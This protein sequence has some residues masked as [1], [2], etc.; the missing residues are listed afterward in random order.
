MCE[1]WFKSFHISGWGK[2]KLSL[3]KELGGGGGS[4]TYRAWLSTGIMTRISNYVHVKLQDVI[5]YPYRNFNGG[6]VRPPL[7]LGCR[8]A[9]PQNILAVTLHTKTLI[10]DA[11]VQI[12]HY[13]DVTMSLMASQI[14]SLTS[15]YST[16]Y[17]GA[18]QRKHQSSAPLAFVWG[19]HRGPVN[20]THKW[21][22]TRK[23]FPFDDVI[24]WTR[25]WDI[26]RSCESS[27]IRAHTLKHIT[28]KSNPFPISRFIRN[29]WHVILSF[30]SQCSC[31]IQR[32]SWAGYQSASEVLDV[33]YLPTLIMDMCIASVTHSRNQI[34]VRCESAIHCINAY[35]VVIG[36][37]AG[38]QRRLT[39]CGVV[40][41]DTAVTMACNN[42]QRIINNDYILGIS[43]H[44]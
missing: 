7:K 2:A 6:S 12:D 42:L 37:T 43:I 25:S 27:L 8:E 17:L 39:T 23:K 32:M 22:V 30:R 1:C 13:D 11:S 40:N 16:V 21:S 36:G 26:S 3:M 28:S 38:C 14:T 33:I 44:M 20:S 15:V 10:S 29:E 31:I 24:M 18:D 9:V 4:F 19:I 5:T 41:D 35:F 34:C